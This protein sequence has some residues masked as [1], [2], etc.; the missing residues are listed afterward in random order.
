[1][2]G[3]IWGFFRFRVSLRVSFSKSLDHE[4][5]ITQERGAKDDQSLV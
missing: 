4:W 2:S 5:V 3:F 1:M